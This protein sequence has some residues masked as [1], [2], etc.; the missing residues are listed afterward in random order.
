MTFPLTREQAL[1]AAK[2][3]AAERD[4]IQSNLLDLDN[5]FGKR[6]LAGASLTGESRAGW[7]T[8]SASLAAL[9]DTFTA[10]SAVIDRANELLSVPGR[11]TP[12]RLSEVA[13]LLNGPSITMTKAVAPLSQR[14]LTSSG[15]TQQTLLTTVR[16]MRRSFS[17]V[18]AVVTAAE[19]VWNEIS[20]GIRLVTTDIETAKAQLPGLGADSELTTAVEQAD[21]SL[22]DLRGL[23]NSDPLALWRGGAVDSALLDRLRKQTAA[24]TAQVAELA[25]VRADADQRLAEIASAVSAAQ[26]AYQDATAARERAASRISLSAAHAFSPLPDLSLLSSRAGALPAMKAAGRWTRLAS[27]LDVIG[28]QAAA[29]TRQCKEAE[30]AAAD[31][32]GKRNEMRGLLDSY[33]AMAGGLGAAENAELDAVY[34]Q[35]K[36]LL[37]T[38]PCDLEAATAAVNGYQQ[39]VLRLRRSGG[40]R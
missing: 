26:Q 17:E 18:A 19:T 16:E 12:A 9:W 22:R 11:I 7:D 28:K 25:R 38:A 10:Y 6:L 21:A 32:V 30:Q 29:V 27:E 3:A 39:A 33:R 31:L 14:E 4:T 23:L 15:L 13:S 35:A 37:W 1:A 40:R 34:Q 8:A 24:V 5:S 36:Q 2:A 20:D